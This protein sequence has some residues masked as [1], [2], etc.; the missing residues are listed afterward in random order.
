MD[1]DIYCKCISILSL[2]SSKMSSQ[3]TA[4]VVFMEIIEAVAIVID[5]TDYW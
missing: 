4:I 5:R 1:L 2:S 3:F